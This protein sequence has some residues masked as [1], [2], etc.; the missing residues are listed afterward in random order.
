MPLKSTLKKLIRGADRQE[1]SRKAGVFIFF[2]IAALVLGY[3]F[4]FWTIEYYGSTVYSMVV[5]GFTL[6]MVLSIVGKL[7]YDVTLTRYVASGQY[8]LKQVGGYLF[9]SQLRVL[10]LSGL[11]AA[12]LILFKDWIATEVFDKPDFA[13]YLFWTALAIPLWSLIYIHN[14]LYRGLKKNTLFSFYTAFGRF[15]LAIIL[16]LGTYFIFG[17]GWEEAPIVV[18]FVALFLLLASC[19]WITYY[20]FGYRPFTRLDQ[21][22]KTFSTASTPILVTSVVG[23]LLVW[24]DRLFVGAYLGDSDTGIYDVGA[25]LALLVS[26]NLD[27]I[28]SILAPKIVELYQKENIRPLQQLLNFSVG[29]S[30]II[31]VVTFVMLYFGQDFLLGF[32]GPEYQRA[33]GVLM[34][35]AGGQLL[36]CLCGSV[37]NILQMT[38]HQKVH[39][40]IMLAGLGVNLTLNFLLVRPFGLEGVAAATLSG[41]LCWNVLGAYYVQKKLGLR[42]YLNPWKLKVNLNQ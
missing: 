22:F 23:I 32:F 29:V 15:L 21:S 4:T 10:G 11:V 27:A 17:P 12:M 28:N 8:G 33:G 39:Q 19:T 16:L 25:K 9:N 20:R 7:G 42:S 5:L 30:G 34:I 26:F 2:R 35:L 40:R 14:G 38:G 41:M 31:A 36:N 37:G 1:L 18:H 13:T 3:A 6:F 24:V